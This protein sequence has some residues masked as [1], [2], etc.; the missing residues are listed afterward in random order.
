LAKVAKKRSPTI[1][2]SHLP[3]SFTCQNLPPRLQ[4]SA[5]RI[6][7]P[8]HARPWKAF[9]RVR[10]LRQRLRRPLRFLRPFTGTT[11]VP[12]RAMAAASAGGPAPPNRSLPTRASTAS[13][14]PDWWAGSSAIH[15]C[16]GVVIGGRRHNLVSLNWQTLGDAPLA[17]YFTE[18]PN[19][20]I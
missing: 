13:P 16:G 15:P 19:I 3:K 1:C 5:R 14:P 20:T 10:Q 6:P 7:L 9:V 17:I 12:R 2:Y 11:A 8:N 4:F 18:L